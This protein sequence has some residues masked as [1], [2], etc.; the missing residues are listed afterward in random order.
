MSDDSEEPGVLEKTDSSAQN[1]TSFAVNDMLLNSYT[2]SQT[3][4]NSC[5]A[6]SGREQDNEDETACE[7]QTSEPDISCTSLQGS[8]VDQTHQRDGELSG[9][10]QPQETPCVSNIG[11]SDAQQIIAQQSDCDLHNTGL[12]E[13]PKLS[14]RPEEEV[15]SGVVSSDS[16]SSQV[17]ESNSTLSPDIGGDTQ[18]TQVSDV[19]RDV[20]IGSGSSDVKTTTDTDICNTEHTQHSQPE[21]IESPGADQS[22]TQ[23]DLNLETQDIKPVGQTCNPKSIDCDL[24]EVSYS[25]TG[26]GSDDDDAEAQHDSA[27]SVAGDSKR[28]RDADNISPKEEES[29][30]RHPQVHS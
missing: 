19:Q 26:D 6:E 16:S 7:S 15:T 24:T 25:V 22:G 1:V 18:Q 29:K 13:D 28:K 4:N 23:P 11:G 9:V 21:R 20:F 30:K 2:T 27:T 12:S 5:N 17:L 8:S 10:N 3:S 14:S